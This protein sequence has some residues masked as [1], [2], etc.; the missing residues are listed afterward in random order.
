M[1]QL[2]PV[3]T[4]LC[5]EV[6]VSVE[7]GFPN[8][9]TA[10]VSTAFEDSVRRQLGRILRS[11]AFAN[12]P[13][14]SRFLRYLVE[15]TLQ[16][17]ETPLNEYTLGV[18][19]FDRGESFDPYTDNIVRVQVRRLRSKLHKYYASEGQVDRL[20]IDVPRGGYEAAFRAAAEDHS[21]KQNFNHDS[22]GLAN[23]RIGL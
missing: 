15:R 1:L 20:V 11:S 21:V 12:A 5:S 6:R 9:D 17:D 4:N 22:R 7:K 23:V 3:Y 8:G 2:S 13:S 14:L 19:V 10:H 16:G 18:E